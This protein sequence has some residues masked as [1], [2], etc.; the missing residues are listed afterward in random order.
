M[1]PINQ[2]ATSKVIKEVGA[3]LG[4]AFDGDFDRCFFF[5]EN[6][7]FVQGEYMVDPLLIYF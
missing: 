1:L 6:G 4:V 2:Y 3:D 5:D 7:I